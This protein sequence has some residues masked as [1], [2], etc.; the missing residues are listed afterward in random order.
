MR[1]LLPPLRG[2]FPDFP[3]R[4]ARKL[5]PDGRFPEFPSPRAGDSLQ[6]LGKPAAEAPKPVHGGAVTRKTRREGPKTL[7][8]GPQNRKTCQLGSGGYGNSGN[9]PAA[10]GLGFTNPENPPTKRG[11]RPW[12]PQPH[13]QRHRHP[14]ADAR[15]P[16]TVLSAALFS[17]AC[18]PPS[19]YATSAYARRRLR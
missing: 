2:R 1:A 13:R 14:P 7:H 18:A 17:A 3:N 4:R 5:A 11:R 6:Q 12:P 10:K 8:G 16:R 9:P 19:R 15:G